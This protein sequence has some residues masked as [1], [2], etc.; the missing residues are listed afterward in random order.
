[1]ISL[2]GDDHR[3][4]LS[5]SSF[6]CTLALGNFTRANSDL[7]TDFKAALQ[8]ST[9]SNT[10][11]QSLSIFARLVD[12]EGTDDNHVRRHSELS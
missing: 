10:A 12:I 1:M 4:D 7:V 8:D 9:S 11:L 3:L 2:E 6:A 5:P